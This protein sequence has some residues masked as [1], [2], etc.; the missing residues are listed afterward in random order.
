MILW[1][2]VWRRFMKRLHTEN[3]LNINKLKS[4]DHEKIIVFNL[5]Y[6]NGVLI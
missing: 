1:K 4:D 5:P 3:Q 2:S 6:G